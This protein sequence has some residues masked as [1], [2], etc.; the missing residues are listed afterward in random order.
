M[1]KDTDAPS[2]AATNMHLTST[3][4]ARIKEVIRLRKRAERDASGLFLVEGARE[5]SRALAAHWQIVSFF[6]CPALHATA[7]AEEL[8]ARAKADGAM[9]FECSAEVF[10]KIAYKEGADGWLAVVRQ[11]AL[12]LDDLAL[13]DSPLLLVAEAIEKPGNLGAILRAADGAGVDAMILCDGCTDLYNPNVVRNSMGS[14][15]ALPV[16]AATSVETRAFLRGH[17]IRTIAA[18]PGAQR[19]YSSADL[20]GPVAVVVGAESEGLSSTWMEQA[21]ERVRIPMRGM[22][23]SLNVACATT[24]L[25]YEALRQRSA[26]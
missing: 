12:G 18:T 1:R 11:R 6:S 9:L 26:T 25:L 7:E 15:F 10:A 22:A 2:R 13:S 17:S 16:A 4:N 23:D 3:Q 8:Q 21:D 5:V 20:R 19:I 24:L 14:L